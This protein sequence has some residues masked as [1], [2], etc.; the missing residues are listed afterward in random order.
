VRR[1]RLLDEALAALMLSI[2]T[3]DVFN[4]LNVT[5]RPVAGSWGPG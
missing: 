3:T 4:G 5:T 2:A 1:I